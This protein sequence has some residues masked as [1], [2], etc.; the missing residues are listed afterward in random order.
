MKIYTDYVKE[1]TSHYYKDYIELDDLFSDKK[2][3]DLIKMKYF[4]SKLPENATV[5]L[6]NDKYQ[7]MPSGKL[8]DKSDAVVFKNKM[9][10]NAVQLEL[11]VYPFTYG[12]DPRWLFNITINITKPTG[13]KCKYPVAGNTDSI[14]YE[15]LR[16]LLYCNN[17][18]EWD[19]IYDVTLN[20]HGY[21][22]IDR[23][24]GYNEAEFLL[25]NWLEGLLTVTKWTVNKDEVKLKFN[26]S[27]I[28]EFPESLD[29]LE[30]ET[31]EQL[32]MIIN[33]GR[34]QGLNVTLDLTSEGQFLPNYTDN[35]CDLTITRGNLRF[36]DKSHLT[37]IEF[38][39]EDEKL[40]SDIYQFVVDN[41]TAEGELENAQK[42][43]TNSDKIEAYY[44]Y[45]KYVDKMELESSKFIQN[46]INT[47][48]L[49]IADPTVLVG[50][51]DEYMISVVEPET[52][53]IKWSCNFTTNAIIQMHVSDEKPSLAITEEC[54]KVVWNY[55]Y[56]LIYK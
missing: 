54:K 20:L 28:S 47:L 11:D 22:A 32:K 35:T 40:A 5:R 51:P 21:I 56:S 50:V 38:D 39:P 1:N 15:D 44:A 8:T 26:D 48:K 10:L 31:K 29:K 3:S 34:S 41:L 4:I 25:K 19:Y 16:N 6:I 46:A 30:D 9:T 12:E 7:I 42:D 27:P 33:K 2:M 37:N 49:Y 53:V 18:T 13:E 36:S 23:D 17:L 52:N 24:E 55:M 14:I 45:S 43:S